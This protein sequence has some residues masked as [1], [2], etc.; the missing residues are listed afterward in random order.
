MVPPFDIFRMKSG[1]VL[2]CEAA[3]TV[4]TAQERI[5]ELALSSPG[6]YLILWRDALTL[7]TQTIETLVSGGATLA[8]GTQNSWAADGRTWVVP[9][10]LGR[11]AAKVDLVRKNQDTVE[12]E[13]VFDIEVV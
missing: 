1:F 5:R 12:A 13:V 4:E 6:G 2:W 3:A 10:R 8:S 9:L 7:E 11:L